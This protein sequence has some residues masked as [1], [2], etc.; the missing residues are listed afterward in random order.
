[1]L[2]LEPHASA[3]AFIDGAATARSK[4]PRRG[5]RK[6]L[7]SDIIESGASSKSAPPRPSGI[8]VS[9]FSVGKPSS[10]VVA[11]FNRAGSI[12]SSNRYKLAHAFPR[13]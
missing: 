11:C 2:V 13:L 9:E 12:E 8:G 6:G 10:V 4:K 5:S 7:D 3:A 1:M